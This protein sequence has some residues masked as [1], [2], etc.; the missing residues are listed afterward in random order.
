MVNSRLCETAR[1]AFSVRVRDFLDC[2]TRMETPRWLHEKI[3]T[4]RRTEPLKNKTARPMKFALTRIFLKT[5]H[6][7]FF[8]QRTTT[9]HNHIMFTQLAVQ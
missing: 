8:A 1:L 9:L 2:K 4:A 6:H 5:I 7:S 3:K